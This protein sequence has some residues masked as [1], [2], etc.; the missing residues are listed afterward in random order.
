MCFP[1]NHDIVPAI[2][3]FPK[4]IDELPAILGAEKDEYT[5]FTNGFYG[6]GGFEIGKERRTPHDAAVIAHGDTYLAATRRTDDVGVIQ[7]TVIDNERV[8]DESSRL[9]KRK[10]REVNGAEADSNTAGKVARAP[11]LPNGASAR[12][13]P[14][15]EPLTCPSAMR[16][17]TNDNGDV[18][19]RAENMSDTNDDKSDYILQAFEHAKKVKEQKAKAA[20]KNTNR[21][22]V[23]VRFG[24]VS[25]RSSVL[26]TPG[27]DSQDSPLLCQAVLPTRKNRHNISNNKIGES[28]ADR[29]KWLRRDIL[30]WM[31]S[32]TSA[33]GYVSKL[34]HNTL[35]SVMA[36]KPRE[37]RV[38]V[39]LNGKLLSYRPTQDD[40]RTPDAIIDDILGFEDDE[41]SY[42]SLSQGEQVNSAMC[43]LDCKKL[44]EVKLPRPPIIG[45]SAPRRPPLLNCIPPA[46]CGGTVQVVCAA[47]GTLERT[48][49]S[50][51]FRQQQQGEKKCSVCWTSEGEVKQCNKCGVQ[52]HPSCCAH[53]GVLVPSNNASTQ[54]MSWMCAVCS[55]GPKPTTSS[56]SPSPRKRA[57]TIP[58]RYQSD[59]VLGM[60]LSRS[61]D[62]SASSSS[63]DGA[64][65]CS[66]CPHSGG[67]MSPIGSGGDWCH[68]VCRIWSQSKV[69]E[70]DEKES[71]IMPKTMSK[72]ALCGLEGNCVIKC[73]GSGCTV[74]F[75]P[76]CAMISDMDSSSQQHASTDHRLCSM[77]TVDLLQSGESLL[78]VGFC[79][80][81]NPCRDVFLYG[82]YPGGMGSSMRVPTSQ[83]EDSPLG[84]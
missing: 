15:S 64:L 42:A 35:P 25:S 3:N 32:N 18:V 4:D 14:S 65:K 8:L 62:S 56:L 48:N 83:T 34:S 7:L 68:E 58:A 70:E 19:M 24:S 45:N 36:K 78:P 12:N 38:G 82:C 76:M 31:H 74:R 79:G 5:P 50:N 49:I 80:F 39:R 71:S 37:V 47:P 73:A 44:M 27:N 28:Q 40:A 11:P 17:T 53:G 20:E 13:S 26:T 30:S 66:L 51:L 22:L 52:V 57:K 41:P 60:D 43:M 33:G 10:R 75:H 81:H 63:V 29:A 23:S 61:R 59:M 9:R 16:S 6:Y 77:F 55:E 67:A 46:I 72:C 2:R 21:L 69:V 84:S 54:D 1:W